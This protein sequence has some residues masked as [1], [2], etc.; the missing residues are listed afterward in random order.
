MKDKELKLEEIETCLTLGGANTPQA[1]LSAL[2]TRL[3]CPPREGACFAASES[4][5][6]ALR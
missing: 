6:D 2:T 4:F 3:C 1:S 5:G